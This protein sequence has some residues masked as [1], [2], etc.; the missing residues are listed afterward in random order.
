MEYHYFLGPGV[1]KLIYIIKCF[2][3]DIRK[4]RRI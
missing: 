2:Y 3:C 4:I 1:F